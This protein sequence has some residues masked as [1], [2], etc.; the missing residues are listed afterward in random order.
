MLEWFDPTWYE[1]FV[2]EIAPQI[3]VRL[4]AITY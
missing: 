1:R 2:N 4:F 3:R